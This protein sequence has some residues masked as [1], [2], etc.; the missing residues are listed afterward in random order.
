MVIRF[1][2]DDGFRQVIFR[3]SH[4][5]TQFTDSIYY[6]LN[7]ACHFKGISK[8]LTFVFFEYVDI[9]HDKNKASLTLHKCYHRTK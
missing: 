9:F 7:K 3:N 2:I 6:N 5:S 8:Q 1:K 4:I